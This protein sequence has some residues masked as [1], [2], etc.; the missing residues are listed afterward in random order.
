PRQTLLGKV[1]DQ[2]TQRPLTGAKV[3]VLGTNPLK[4]GY[5]DQQGNFAIK[6]IPVGRYEIR[7][8]Y[9]GFKPLLKTG[10]LLTAGKE[11]FLEIALEE[12]VLQGGE[13]VIEANQ[14]KV[15]NA[16]AMV[17]ARS[18]SVEELRRIPGGAD[19]PARMAVK[20]PGVAPNPDALVNELNV[21]GNAGRAVIWRLEGIDIY[22][23]NHFAT[24]AGN[25]GSVT[26]F[27]QQL[28][29]NTDFFS[30]AFPADYGNALGAVFDARFRNGS[31]QK[32]QHAIQ[33][34]MLGIDAATEGP[35]GSGG[36][37]SYL[38]NYR[39]ST[40]GIVKEFVDV[41]AAIPT[42]QDLSFKLHFQLP[43][44]ATLNVFGIG[45]IS[46]TEFIPTLDTARWGEDRLLNFDSQTQTTTGSVGSTYSQ[47]IGTKSFLQTGV[48][49]TG[50]NYAQSAG[51]LKRDL[52]TIDSISKTNDYEYRLS[53]ST[54][55]NHKFGPRHTHRS[56]VILHGMTT[57]V[58]FIRADNIQDPDPGGNLNDTVRRGNGQAF[59]VNAYSRSQFSLSEKLQLNVGL[60]LMYFGF[61]GETSLEPRLGI[62]YQISPKQSLS[63]GY[64]LHS[65]IEPL[66]TYLAEVQNEQGQW[67]RI[68]DDL[69]FNKAHHLVLSYRW[70]ASENLRLGVELYHQEQF[71]L[72][73]GENLPIS[74]VGGA[75][76]FFESFE[77]NNGGRGQ[78]TGMELALERNFARGYY[79]ITNASLFQ[80]TYAGNDGVFRPSRFNNG[81][82]A[83]GIIGKEW[84]VGK[85][86][87]KSNLFNANFSVTYSGAQYYTPVD[88][89]L[90]LDSG[91]VQS[92]Y[93]NPNSARQDPLFFF[94]ASLVYQINKQGRSSQLSLQVRNILNQRPLT[95]QFFNR[96]TGTLADIY[97]TGFIPLIAWR[98]QF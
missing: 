61:T 51:Y 62:R 80:A 9:L 27:S 39:Y 29:A 59:L 75:D 3:E 54:F 41:G 88:L 18:F 56:G 7:I 85:K 2:S 44:Q 86:K 73:V 30:G 14:R 21:R 33:L 8:S 28:L 74:R 92:D 31:T 89:Q 55:F 94:D 1:T 82:I 37:N 66:F 71:N 76:F 87:G 43:N 78:N 93:L 5:T 47:A 11:T 67:Y 35:I 17:S 84:E 25:N 23:P 72:V 97:G 6:D 96:E 69:R 79:F 16:A 58:L 81:L 15:T 32:R 50:L 60:H 49:A 10:I 22:N 70:Q 12:Q 20:F 83:N 4:G 57:N 45:G 77:L 95:R 38:A 34:S 64:G 26:L 42:Y 19:D 98:M 48:I 63:F 46:L 24:V 68:N 65:Q 52:V 36:N 90:A 91:L 40:T 53:W 13:V